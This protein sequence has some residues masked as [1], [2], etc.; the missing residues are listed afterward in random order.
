MRRNA[1]EVVYKT[2][3]STLF[4]GENTEELF[5]ELLEDYKLDDDDKEFAKN[6]LNAVREHK[7]ELDRII[8]GL[9][10][11]YRL[12]RIYSTDRCALYL[13]ISEMTYFD[14]VPKIVAIDEALALCRVY[15][16]AESLN[17]VNGIFAEYKKILEN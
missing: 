2:I 6:L 15:S 4:N 1:R 11:N 5:N 9:A 17:F 16:T 3:Y 8:S 12:E 10:R 14:D 13:G 7:D